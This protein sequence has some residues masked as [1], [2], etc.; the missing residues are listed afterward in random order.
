MRQDSVNRGKAARSARDAAPADDVCFDLPPLFGGDDDRRMAQRAEAQWRAAQLPHAAMPGHRAMATGA[1]GAFA[2]HALLLDLRRG[3]RVDVLFAG[4]AV[5]A[6]FGIGPGY[7]ASDGDGGLAALLLDGCELMRLWQ[8]IV[9]VDAAVAGSTS[10]CLLTRG[11]LLPLADDAGALAYVHGV[12]NWKQLLDRAAS[13]NLRREVN[14]V[15][16][17]DLTNFTAFPESAREI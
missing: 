16:R 17:G 6:A 9:P 13:E 12:F 4:A 1:A 8:A 5:T 2:G 7:L 14:A 10:A 3:D 15:L 11:V